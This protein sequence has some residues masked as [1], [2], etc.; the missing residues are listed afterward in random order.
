M[1]KVCLRD[2][3]LCTHPMAAFRGLVQ[4][5]KSYPLETVR[6]GDEV[7]HLVDKVES[8]CVPTTRIEDSLVSEDSCFHYLTEVSE[9]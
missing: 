7:F 3:Q 4:K 1:L 2:F 9:L 5:V 6:L 8:H